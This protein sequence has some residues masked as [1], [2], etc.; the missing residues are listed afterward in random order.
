MQSLIIDR[1]FSDE[2][3]NQK[4]IEKNKDSDFMKNQEYDKSKL[5]LNRKQFK[6]EYGQKL[7]DYF[8]N[9]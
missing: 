2:V 9:F 3:D 5:V 4:F 7:K 1:A 6:N 8:K